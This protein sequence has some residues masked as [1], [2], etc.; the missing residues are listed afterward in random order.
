[1]PCLPFL[2]SSGDPLPPFWILTR[3]G[4]LTFSVSAPI[5]LSEHKSDRCNSTSVAPTLGRLPQ[6]GRSLARCLARNPA[7]RSSRP[8]GTE[9]LGKKHLVA[10]NS[11]SAAFE[12]R[13]GARPPALQGTRCFFPSRSVPRGRELR[14][15]GFR[16]RHRARL[17]PCCGSRP[18]VGATEVELRRSLLCS[19]SWIGAETENVSVP[20]RVRIQNGGR[21]CPDE[22]RN[23]RHGIF[24]D[25][26]DERLLIG[27]DLLNFVKVRLALFF[28]SGR[29][30]R[31]HQAVQLSFPRGGRL[32]LLWIPLMIL[33]RAEPD[34]HL[35]V[36][37]EVRVH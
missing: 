37:I 20:E 12:R 9:R 32:R 17:R 27:D 30:L 24:V 8:G 29:G 26:I 35:A 13:R 3:S 28:G 7:R 21:G 1:M 31:L 23:G 19:E 15:A 18:R 6:Q 33:R 16:A 36:G 34:V 22:G 11:P 4:T 14:R 25:E 5:L 2:P 10:R